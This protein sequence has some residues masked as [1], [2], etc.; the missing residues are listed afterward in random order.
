MEQINIRNGEYYYG[1]EKC[2]DANDLYCRFRTDY[3]RELGRVASKRL[4]KPVREERIHGFGFCFDRPVR[5]EPRWLKYKKVK[6][7]LLGLIGTSYYRI[8]GIWD[9]PEV[10]DDEYEDWFDWAFS[11][12]SKA[13]TLVGKNERY[14]R[15]GKISNTYKLKY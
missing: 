15:T 2:S 8:F 10:T 5:T 3:H 11:Q 6:Y 13:I 12:N 4:D 9:C 1:E 7:R 14:G